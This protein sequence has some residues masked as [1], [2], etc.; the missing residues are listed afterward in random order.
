VG[1]LAGVRLIGPVGV[2][3]GP[4]LV[5]CAMEFAMLYEREYGLPWTAADSS[6]DAV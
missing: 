3:M 6:R 2:L 1:V 5:Q 4:A